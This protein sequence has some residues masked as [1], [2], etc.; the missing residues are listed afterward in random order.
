MKTFVGKVL[1]SSILMAM[2]VALIG[3][4]RTTT[5]Q[6][7]FHYNHEDAPAAIVVEVESGKTVEAPTVSRDG[8][9]FN[10]WFTT[11]TGTQAFDFD[12]EINED[13]DVYAQWDSAEE[14]VKVTFMHNYEGS[15]DAIVRYIEAGETPTAEAVTREGYTFFGWFLDAEGQQHYTF[16]EGIDEDLV[17]YAYWVEAVTY[18]LGTSANGYQTP[19]DGGYVFEPVLGRPGFYK[20]VIEFTEA[21]RDPMYDGH[22]YKVSRG[23]WGANETWG[24][25]HYAFQPAPEKVLPDGQVAGL[26][27]IYIK[28]NTTLTILFDA[29]T[30]TIYD[31]YLQVLP[32]P[33]IYGDFNE[34]MG[35]GPNWSVAKGEA[36]ELSERLGDGLYTGLF[37]LPEYTG[38]GDGF[39]MVVA[40][41][42]QFNMEWN[43]F[44]VVEQ[45][46]FDGTPAGMGD[47]SYLSPTE[48]T[49]Y[50]FFF[51][52][53]T[54]ELTYVETFGGEVRTFDNPRIYGSFNHWAF[55]G[56]NAF[57]LFDHYGA[58]VFEGSMVLPAFEDTGDGHALI[59]AL[60]KI[61][62]DDEWGIR[63]GIHE[64]YLFDGSA[65]GMGSA[66]YINNAEDAFTTF[67]FD[68]ND[69]TTTY[70]MPEHGD[71]R[72]IQGPS[73][74]GDFNGWDY[75]GPNSV[76]LYDEEGDG[77][78]R[79]ILDLPA[80]TEDGDGYMIVVAI[81]HQFYDDEWG[82]RW[83]V[84]TQYKLDGS[85]AAMGAVSYIAPEEDTFYMIVYDSETHI[86]EL[87]PV[88]GGD[89]VPFS[90]PRIYGDFNGWQINGPQAM[91]MQATEE[92]GVYVG[93]FYFDAYDGDDAGY[94]IAV[95]LSQRFYDDEWGKRFGAEEQYLLDGSPAGMG[96]IDYFNPEVSG[97]YRFTFDAETS[98]TTIELV[99]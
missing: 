23:G 46:K 52:A 30:K 98:I 2:F 18:Y 68:I 5:H 78:Y 93:E 73:V 28:E 40:L 7:T 25:D 64:Q 97:V 10:G 50:E 70:I 57:E 48:E 21:N 69:K 3:C 85:L 32:V 72:P 26:G 81:T 37:K 65:A 77:I 91:A 36:L 63:W 38:D 4:A 22:Y 27:S 75:F 95:A 87:I 92:E 66:S 88:E 56:A 89:V 60:S 6:V 44:T 74:Y 55:R 90:T 33:R 31:D 42:V 39:S 34:A 20:L 11:A 29:N 1:T 54:K 86:T 15:P 83:A 53:D 19:R 82:Q 59:V 41:S 35:R 9:V 43:I 47:V 96:L 79:G 76:F 84:G 51:D 12:M 61:L 80:Y 24:V 58:G 62:Y 94:M 16:S 13:V 8:Y 99:E 45:Y 14:L 49:I 67:I 17:L 71:E